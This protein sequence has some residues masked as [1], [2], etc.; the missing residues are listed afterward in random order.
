MAGRD[1]LMDF[2]NVKKP[3]PKIH[4]PVTLVCS[5]AAPLPTQGPTSRT[6]AAF[7]PLSV[8]PPATS[9]EGRAGH[10]EREWREYRAAVNRQL[11]EVA[12]GSVHGSV[13]GRGTVVR[14]DMSGIE[15]DTVVGTM[16]VAPHSEGTDGRDLTKYF[17][18]TKQP[19]EAWK[20]PIAESK[21]TILD[22]V[23]AHQIVV[24]SGPTGCGKSTQVPQYLL[25]QH[26][27]E[28][29]AVN[30][31][32][33]QP[34]KIAASSVARRGCQER[35]WTLGG[36][37]GYQVGLDRA[38]KSP[39]TRLIYVTTGILKVRLSA[40]FHSFIMIVLSGC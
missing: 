34:R 33:T 31:L 37:V 9:S 7:D 32:V 30:I 17:D 11:Q 25:D 1:D 38:N 35:G 10:A 36:L 20:L 12:A 14:S 29:R 26:A 16:S 24:I 6:C 18:F 13:A 22:T 4:F 2:F 23:A 19:E 8:P 15:G 39:D 5:C 40:C 28:R 3:F 27:K 21:A